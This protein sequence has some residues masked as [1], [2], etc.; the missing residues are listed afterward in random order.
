VRLVFLYGPPA[1]GKLTIAREVAALT[2]FRVFHNHATVDALSTVFEF[3]TAPFVELRERVWLDV[4]GEAA[5][6]GLPG[7]VFTFVPE[8]TVRPTFVPSLVERVRNAGGVVHFVKL[9]CPDTE[10]ERRLDDPSRRAFQKLRSVDLFRSLRDSGAF[11]YPAL[12]ADL[13]LDT[14]Q[15]DAK[16]GAQRLVAHFG[17]VRAPSPK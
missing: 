11:N 3:G 15:M 10:V 8:R 14:S 7:L 6:T 2:G 9:E 1:A 13:I 16:Q 4:M 17:L 12:A 5:R